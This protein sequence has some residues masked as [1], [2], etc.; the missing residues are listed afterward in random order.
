MEQVRGG[1]ISMIF[2]EPMTSLN[3]VYRVGDQIVEAIQAHE[4]VDKKDAWARAVEMLRLVGIP[5]RRSART[6]I[7]TRCPAVCASAS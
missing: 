7:R 6:T 1:N 5:A 2:Q 4:Q 3:P